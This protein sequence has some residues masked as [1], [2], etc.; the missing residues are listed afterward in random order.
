MVK[1]II[2][3]HN[4]IDMNLKSWA[5]PEKPKSSRFDRPAFYNYDTQTKTE[6]DQDTTVCDFKSINESLERENEKLRQELDIVTR[7]RD[8]LSDLYNESLKHK[9]DRY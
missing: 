7:S 3:E 9:R 2:D 4:Q 8:Y 5:E 1:E 6:E